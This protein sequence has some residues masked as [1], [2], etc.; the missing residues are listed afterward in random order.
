MIEK[1][2]FNGELFALIISNH[3]PKNEGI[4]FLTDGDSLLEFGIMKYK[5]GHTIQP[6]IHKPIKRIIFG[7]NEV[8]YIKKGKVLIDFFDENQNQFSSKT[9]NRGDWVILI[10]GGHG[11]KIIENSELIEVKN[12]P[13]VDGNDKVKF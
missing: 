8:I 11:F 6:H 7:T 13:Y 5:S 2:K 3:S 10:K 1:I 12:G 4:D 9:L